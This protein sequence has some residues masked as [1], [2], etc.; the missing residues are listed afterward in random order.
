MNTCSPQFID[1]F[2]TDRRMEGPAANR[3]IDES[4]DVASEF[5][6]HGGRSRHRRR[7]STAA[8]INEQQDS[9]GPFARPAGPPDQGY[10]GYQSQAI[11]AQHTSQYSGQPTMEEPAGYATSPPQT[12]TAHFPSTKTSRH[13][14]RRRASDYPD[15]MGG[16]R[17]ANA[18]L[19]GHPTSS[20][21]LIGPGEESYAQGE[22]D[23]SF[24]WPQHGEHQDEQR[25]RRR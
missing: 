20:Q 24:I 11:P 8:H 23:G 21:S 16:P 2:G 19:R 4:N 15:V 5:D 13:K 17:S 14:H 12:F 3:F 25:S 7:T 18:V 1:P 6:H 9:A 22:G 10:Q